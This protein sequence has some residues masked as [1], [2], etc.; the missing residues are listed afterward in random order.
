M[1]KAKLSRISTVFWERF[2]FLKKRNYRKWLVSDSF[3]AVPDTL[4]E[5]P[6]VTQNSHPDAKPEPDF[7]FDQNEG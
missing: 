5:C 7:Q 6:F 3:A 1:P 2:R 4:L